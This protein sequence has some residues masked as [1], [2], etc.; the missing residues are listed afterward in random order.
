MYTLR[1]VI[2]KNQWNKLIGDEYSLIE[3]DVDYEEFQLVF[4]TFFGKN[5]VAD[6]DSESDRF[7]KETYAFIVL[8]I[9]EPIP[10]YKG[11][12]NYIMTDSGKTFSNLTYRR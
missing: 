12:Y 5:N 11:H 3:R 7:T 9:V 8:P 10:L 6:L 1:K 4:K 2:E